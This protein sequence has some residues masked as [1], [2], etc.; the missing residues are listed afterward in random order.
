MKALL[1]SLTLF[2]Q[3]GTVAPP[4]PAA[5][6]TPPATAIVDP[7]IP[8]ATESVEELK[9]WL[10]SHLIV[11]MKFD[12]PKCAEI[13]KMIDR[14]TD[15]Q[16][17]VLV[18]VYKDRSSKRDQLSKAQQDAAE[19]QLL[20]QAKLD[21]QQSEAYRD[22]LKREYDRRILQGNMTQNLILQNIVN[23][24]RMFY[25]PYGNFA[26]APYGVYSPLVYG[27]IGYP[28][29]NVAGPGLYGNPYYFGAQGY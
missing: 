1:I 18:A 14:L 26:S 23:T 12:A 6:A 27:G 28:P 3:A 13:E 10:L 2:G 20:N 9:A 24:Q 4:V 29:P 7:S 16:V 25:G 8:A 5:L 19:Q 17:R 15:R 21:L 22:H 11:D